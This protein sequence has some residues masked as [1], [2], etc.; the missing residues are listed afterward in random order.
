MFDYAK[1]YNYV[2]SNDNNLDLKNGKYVLLCPYLYSL[3]E[4]K[5]FKNNGVEI[6][7]EIP[8]LDS[9]EFND[10]VFQL[11]NGFYNKNGGNDEGEDE[12][13]N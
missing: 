12:D 10:F 4:I 6:S 5:K 1:F 8:Y 13:V 7:Q 9:K 2:S 3:D 11:W